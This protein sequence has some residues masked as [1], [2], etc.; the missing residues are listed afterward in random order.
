M[1]CNFLMDFMYLLGGKE[2]ELF[3]HGCSP[4]VWLTRTCLSIFVSELL[5]VLLVCSGACICFSFCSS[6]FCTL[7]SPVIDAQRVSLL[8]SRAQ[9]FLAAVG[10][11][12]RERSLLS[13]PQ[14][15]VCP[16]SCARLEC[17]Y[18]DQNV[19]MFLLPAFSEPLLILGK[20]W[21]ASTPIWLLT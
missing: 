14:P 2:L 15:P 10:S 11:S 5:H 13:C 21:S 4:L 8:C 17:V 19:Q 9:F 20:W 18:R 6:A 1:G 12:R 16:R 3:F 7:A